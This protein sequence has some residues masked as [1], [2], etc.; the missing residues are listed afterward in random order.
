M[1]R[2]GNQLLPCD[3]EKRVRFFNSFSSH[4]HDGLTEPKLTVFTDEANFNLSG[5]VNSENNRC[6]V[7]PHALIQLPLYDN[8]I[9]VWC[10]ISANQINGSIFYEGTLEARSR[11]S[12]VGIATSYG[13]DDRGVRIRVPVRSRI[14]SS[15]NRPD[16]HWG[17]PNLLSNW[18]RGL[19]PLG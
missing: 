18:Y 2:S 16:R 17:P 12:V 19:F 3:Y 15:P 14:F 4:V 5:Y 8:K 13:L 9:G 10:A 1:Q 6:C 11:D 7:N